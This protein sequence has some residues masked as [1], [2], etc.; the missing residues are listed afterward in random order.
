MSKQQNNGA[1]ELVKD[2]YML[3]KMSKELREHKR[4]ISSIGKRL[5]S[6]SN[7]SKS[8]MEYGLIENLDIVMLHIDKARNEIE[9][10]KRKLKMI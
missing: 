9:K 2:Y 1:K 4:Y 3:N 10:A 7:R 8:D 5:S 6:I